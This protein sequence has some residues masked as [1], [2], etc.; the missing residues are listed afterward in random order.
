MS[1]ELEDGERIEDVLVFVM[2]RVI[3]NKNEIEEGFNTM[4][5]AEA[6]LDKV[7]AAR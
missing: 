7:E 6:Y 3:T 2:V 4:E 1:L 5:E